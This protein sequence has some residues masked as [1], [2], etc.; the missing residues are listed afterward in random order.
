MHASSHHVEN[1]EPAQLLSM[2]GNRKRTK[3]RQVGLFF[4]ISVMERDPFVPSADLPTHTHLACDT[5]ILAFSHAHTHDLWKNTH[6]IYD[7][8]IV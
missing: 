7:I 8:F 3:F 5:R 6:D 4:I 1:G 2:N